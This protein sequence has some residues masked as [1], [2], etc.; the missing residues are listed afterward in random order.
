MPIYWDILLETHLLLILRAIEY[1]AYSWVYNFTFNMNEF[2]IYIQYILYTFYKLISTSV[3]FE[4]D[5]VRAD[6][7]HI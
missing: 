3:W 1:L 7:D 4:Y 6:Q 5:L 2:N